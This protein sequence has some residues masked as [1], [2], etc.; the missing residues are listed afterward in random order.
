MKEFFTPNYKAPTARD[1][2]VHGSSRPGGKSGGKSGAKN[3]GRRL[4]T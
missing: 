1:S 4:L 2:R 3:G